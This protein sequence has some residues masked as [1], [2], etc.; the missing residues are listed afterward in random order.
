MC[1]RVTVRTSPE[2]I[3]TGLGLAG[4]RTA[5]ERPRFNLCPTQLMPVV[6]NDGARMLDAFRWGLVPS[7]AKDPAIG[8]KLINARGETVAEKPSFRSA[9]KRR[10]CLVVVDG[11]Y[12][13]KQ[14]TKPKTPYYFHRKDGQLLTLAGLWEEWTAPDTGEVLNT[15]TIITIGPNALMAPIHDRM[16]VILEPEAQEVWLRPEPQESS[17]LLPLLVPCAEESLDAYEVSRVVNSP[18]NDTPEC[19]ER[20]AA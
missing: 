11:W 13:W 8:N 17:V 16:P 14:S 4:I 10:R 12:E 3:V 1:G 6:T 2:Q 20:V 7:W 9:L 15:C 18:A 5:V 19:V